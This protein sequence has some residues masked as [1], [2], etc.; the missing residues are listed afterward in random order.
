MPDLTQN[1]QLEK[2]TGNEY[3]DVELHGRNMD[4]IDAALAP[5]ADP[6]QVP[7][8][9]GPGK[10]V[11]WVSWLT[12]RIKAITGKTN[13]WD[14]PSKSLE[15][16]NTHSADAVSHITSAERISWNGKIDKSLATAANDFLVASGAG[17]WVKKTLAEVKTI[18]GLG[19]AAYTA[20][21]A[22]ATAAQGTKADNALPKAGGTMTGELNFTDQL[23][24]RPYIKDYAEVVG[25]TP[26]TT[27]PVTFDITTGNV[28]TLTPTG[29]VTIDFSNPPGA[30]RAGSVTLR[31]RNSAT[32]YAKTF[33]AAI[34][35]VGDEIP[36]TS[37]ANKSYDLVFITTDAGATWHGA[38]IGPYSA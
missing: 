22:Y 34:K 30:G 35:W 8:I 24:T 33:A 31:L 6:T 20:S 36:D 12:N 17:A 16:F 11:Q 5:T 26:A 1:Y 32:V 38:C 23:A 37:E 25:T 18:L 19:T 21:T 13:W 29:A 7:T 27:G 10:L 9:N 3:Y 4:K 2:A 15:D 14:A 28:F